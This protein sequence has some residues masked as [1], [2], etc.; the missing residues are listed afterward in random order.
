MVRL[1]CC[2]DYP[3]CTFPGNKRRQNTAY[4]N[5]E[6]NW[7]TLCPVHQEEADQYWEERWAEY[8]AGRMC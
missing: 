3:G 4:V 5:D 2:C 6:L 7:N 8:Y 1:Q